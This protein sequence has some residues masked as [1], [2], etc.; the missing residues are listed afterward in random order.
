MMRLKKGLIL[1]AVFSILSA[2]PFCVLAT[3]GTLTYTEQG[4]LS[5]SLG[6]T[7]FTNAQVT[8]TLAGTPSS[9]NVSG[10]MFWDVF[11]G[12]AATVTIAGIPGTATISNNAEVAVW[13]CTSSCT[14]PAAAFAFY[15]GG[16]VTFMGTSNPAF[17][18]YD[19]TTPIGPLSGT[20]FGTAPPL[21]TD[22]GPF[23]ISSYSGQT[24][25][26]TAFTE[27]PE[28]ESLGLL[29][30]GAALLLAARRRL[31]R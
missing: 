21:D 24:S 7:P 4:N 23:V 10:D 3:A 31:T 2:L 29:A 28:P 9:I 6:G 12:G 16:W 13:Q 25:T 27:V 5:G 19:L 8:F 15:T 22:K 14:N 30:I 18:T 11:P 17:G 26:F 20:M 1:T